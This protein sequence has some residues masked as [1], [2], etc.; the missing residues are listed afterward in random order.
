MIIGLIAALTFLFF[1]HPNALSE[2][3]DQTE[4]LIKKYV[5]DETRQKQALTIVDQAETDAERRQKELQKSV[6]SLS[7]VLLNKRVST[8]SEIQAALNPI[9]AA[10]VGEVQKQLDL[11]FQLKTVLTEA[12]W[13]QVFPL[14][15][16]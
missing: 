7:N 3:Y 16:P 2:Q 8:A 9:D 5:H 10:A 4:G 13:S 11:R 14:P 12:E 6:E 1:P 15:R